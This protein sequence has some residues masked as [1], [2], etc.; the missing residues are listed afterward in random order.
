MRTLDYESRPQLRPVRRIPALS[1][2][3]AL[4]LTYG[5]IFIGAGHGV[6]PLG[7]ILVWGLKGWFAPAVLAYCGISLCFAGAAL[8]QHYLHALTR[9][10]GASLLCSS[11][12]WFF[13]QSEL[14]PIS[15]A[16]GIPFFIC[17][18]SWFAEIFSIFVNMRTARRY[19]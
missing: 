10:F 17:L 8:S 4:V 14:I 1:L 9:I 6:A 2:A 13:S 16:T 5:F 3:L 12:I 19:P 15:V 7:L 18:L 11:A